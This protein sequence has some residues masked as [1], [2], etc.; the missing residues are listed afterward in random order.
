M[1]NL[2]LTHER[3]GG[4]QISLDIYIYTGWN[5]HDN[6]LVN[7]VLWCH[8]DTVTALLFSTVEQKSK[9]E[10]PRRK[11]PLDLLYFAEF[12]DSWLIWHTFMRGG[13]GLKFPMIAWHRIEWAWQ[14]SDKP[15]AVMPLS[16]CDRF[17]SVRFYGKSCRKA[18]MI[19]VIFRVISFPVMIT[20]KKQVQ[21]LARQATRP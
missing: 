2:V 4:T 17:H 11:R 3:R 16:Y 15:N 6:I 21:H 19:S 12:N 18:C 7:L 14:Y 10:W 9:Q 1:V 13:A 20:S 8:S 5:Y